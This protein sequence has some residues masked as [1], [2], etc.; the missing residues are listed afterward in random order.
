MKLFSMAG[1]CAL[2]VHIVLEWIGTPFEVE[3]LNRGDNRGPAYLAINTTGQVPALQLDDGR[4]L[5]EA[6]AILP[7]LAD[8]YPAAGLS[9]DP[10]PFGRY[11][12]ANMLSVLTGEVHVAFKPFFMP[13][14][15]VVDEAQFEAVKAQAFV[16]LAPM[17]AALDA[18]LGSSSFILGD[19]R[20]V[21][22]PYLYVLLRWVDNAPGKLAPYR[23]LARYR[24]A[25]EADPSVRRALEGQGMAPLS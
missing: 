25:A 1:T 12:L 5:T 13:Q 11:E 22:D 14:R 21:A 20:S 7:F 18:R 3:V 24:A 23:N 9:P 6:A 16:I 15:F 19:R 10:T 4:I 8:S 2:S 17:L